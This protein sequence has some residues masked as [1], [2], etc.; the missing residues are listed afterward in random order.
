[1]DM[2]FAGNECYSL[3]FLI[4]ENPIHCFSTFIYN[5]I[6]FE[7]WWNNFFTKEKQF[8]TKVR[9]IHWKKNRKHIFF[10]ENGYEWERFHF[11][12]IMM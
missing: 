1:M 6:I 7:T 12:G 9:Y 3:R 11:K 10:Y 2:I 8:Q 5:V 4:S